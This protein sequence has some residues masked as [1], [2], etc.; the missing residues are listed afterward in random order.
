MQEVL[1]SKTKNEEAAK[2][3]Y[4]LCLAQSG[5]LIIPVYLPES[6]QIEEGDLVSVEWPGGPLQAAVRF[7]RL[8]N[9]ES[10]LWQA[11][12]IAKQMP[13]VRAMEYARTKQI[14]WN[15]IEWGDK[16]PETAK[17]EVTMDLIIG[18][19]AEHFHTT[20]EDIRGSKRDPD[21]IRPRQIAMYLC[22]SMTNASLSSIGEALGKRDHSTIMHGI[23]KADSDIR[24]DRDIQRTIDILKE[25]I[26]QQA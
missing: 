15:H 7:V 1:R 25:K 9:P 17:G 8:C 11:V 24:K 14:V 20:A 6:A 3:S 10:D 2:E 22:R 26:Q 13:P 23:E 4:Y 5:S 12:T 16:E 19:V 21:I 18:T